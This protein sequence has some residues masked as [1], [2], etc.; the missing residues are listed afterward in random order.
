MLDNGYME[1]PVPSQHAATVAGLPA[2]H[3]D[4]FDRILAAALE[5]LPS[6]R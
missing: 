5:Q 1:L 3:K 6:S 4:P 2:I